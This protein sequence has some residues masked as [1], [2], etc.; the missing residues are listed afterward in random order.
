MF[1]VE[2]KKK[3]SFPRTSTWTWKNFHFY[4]NSKRKEKLF[5]FCFMSVFQDEHHKV[6]V[7]FAISYLFRR[8]YGSVFVVVH[9]WFWTKCSGTHNN[10]SSQGQLNDYWF[11]KQYIITFIRSFIS[12]SESDHGWKRLASLR[13]RAVDLPLI[14]GIPTGRS[15]SFKVLTKL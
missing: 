7:H 3:I 6:K 4:Q 5:Y 14:R 10:S 11:C 8:S 9:C 2:V 15:L 12:D 13:I 1:E